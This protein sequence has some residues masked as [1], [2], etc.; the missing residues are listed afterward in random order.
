MS[1][2]KIP[3]GPE[4]HVQGD[5]Q[6]ECTLV[7]YGDYECPH[8]AAAHPI[9]KRLQRHFGKHLRLVYRNFPLTQ[10]HPHAESAA[11]AAEF[12]GSKGKFWET[13]DLLF[14]NQSRLG[15]AL[16]EAIAEE[17]G[18]SALELREALITREFLP[19]VRA[20]FA[21]GVRSGVNGTPTFFINGERHDGPYEYEFLEAAIEETRARVRQ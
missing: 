6:A 5:P 19:T 10:L 1:Q 20:D 4:D 17:L 8:C 2:L 21:G 14:E 13:H 11:E 18:L 16:Y 15:M 7:E 3:V 12:A 9:V